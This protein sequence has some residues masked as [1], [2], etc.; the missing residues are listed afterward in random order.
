MHP[1]IHTPT[2]SFA[3]AICAA[4]CLLAGS[5]APAAPLYDGS[6]GSNPV[7]QGWASLTLGSAAETVGNGS[8]TLD[9]TLS[10]F[11]QTGYSYGLPIDS[12]QGFTLAFRVQV[13]AESHSSN[14]RAGFSVIALDSAHRGVELGFWTDSIWA[15]EVS[16]TKHETAGF[17]TQTAMVDYLLTL[18]GGS[19]ALRVNGSAAPLLAGPMRDYSGSGN[20]IYALGNFLFFGDDTSSASAKFAIASVA[21]VPSPPAWTLMLGPL[22]VGAIRAG[23][24]K[25]REA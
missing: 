9:T 25:G 7:A 19:Y 4:A 23:R 17:D 20:P 5:S 21:T 10:N 13:L 16:F 14:N 12:G 2:H 11:T 15:Q 3:K 18:Q 8:V 22:A 1:D 24:G 6:L